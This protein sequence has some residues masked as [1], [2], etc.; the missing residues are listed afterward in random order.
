MRKVPV[1]LKNFGCF[2]IFD[3]QIEHKLHP[4]SNYYKKLR[5]DSIVRCSSRESCCTRP[6]KATSCCA[7]IETRKCPDEVKIDGQLP[8]E[9]KVE[10]RKRKVHDM[11]Q[12]LIANE[13]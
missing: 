9:L 10:V 6:R 4:C 3:A 12:K 8:I 5:G 7:D 2:T 11:S 1:F 13:M